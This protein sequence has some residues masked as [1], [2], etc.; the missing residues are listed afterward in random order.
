MVIFVFKREGRCSVADGRI[1]IH[2]RPAALQPIV[3]LERIGEAGTLIAQVS[4][5]RCQDFE[6]VFGDE[7][8]S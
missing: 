7:L 3:N 2:S 6:N 5:S 8:E 1:R 4:S